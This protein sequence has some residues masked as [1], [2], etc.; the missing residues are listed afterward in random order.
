M[1]K[2]VEN[3][4]YNYKVLEANLKNLRLTLRNRETE[5][6]IK[7]VG[8]GENI[9]SGKI[10]K[11]T[12]RTAIKNIESQEKVS[13][14]ITRLENELLM[15]E[16]SMNALTDEERRVVTGKYFNG[17][18]WWQIAGELKYSERWC[19]RILKGA[20]EKMTGALT[21]PE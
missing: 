9:S 1:R 17:Q 5:T 11:P 16:N 15:I 7:A 4:L 19:K 18:Q 20:L 10:S 2:E 3:R 14:K 6:D 21:V 13:R 12:E 8:Y